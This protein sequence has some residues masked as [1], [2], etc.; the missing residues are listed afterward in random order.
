[1]KPSV[2]FTR[3]WLTM[4]MYGDCSRLTMSASR[5][6]S[7]NAVSPVVLTKSAT[8]ISSRSLNAGARFG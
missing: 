2:S 3:A 6:V 1:M 5:S 4:L 8:K 7:S